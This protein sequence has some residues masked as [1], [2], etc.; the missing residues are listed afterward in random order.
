VTVEG[1]VIA[2][3][4]GRRMRPL[5]D[6]WPKALLPVDRRPV[7]ATLLRE[8]V[9][10][11]VARVTIVLGRL[12]DQIERLVGDG[13]GF[14]I[15]VSYARQ[16]EPLGSAD[17][18]RR[19]LGSGAQPPVLVTAADT[20]YRPGDLRQALAR[21]VESGA[22]GG[23]GV[24]PVPAS[25]LRER[26]WVR[27]E[28]GR[29]AQVVEKPGSAPAAGPTVPAAAPLWLAGEEIAAFVERVPGPP[30]E[31]ASAFQRAIDAGETVVALE[32]GPTRD[33]TRPAD[34]LLHNFP[35]L[36]VMDED[37]A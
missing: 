16:P 25:E 8:L 7:L 33:L 35:Y 29:V 13:S 11:G 24:R 12:G 3:G 9:T 26:A 17:A 23:L 36:W 14:G 32:L 31:L 28:S 18:V 5:T 37:G 30:F 34:V 20:V 6:R 10:A 2:A 22:A 27:V 15:P 21:F 1:V 4:E 19:A